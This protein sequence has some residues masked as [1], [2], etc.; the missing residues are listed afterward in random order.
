MIRSINSIIGLRNVAFLRKTT[1]Q[2]LCVFMRLCARVLAN[3]GHVRTCVCLFEKE[4][5]EEEGN[6]KGK[7][8]KKG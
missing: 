4:K 5:R 8:K 3:G 1:K 2:S 6:E 7:R